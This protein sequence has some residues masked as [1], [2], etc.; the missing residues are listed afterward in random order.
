MGDVL[1]P[2][3]EMIGDAAKADDGI[4][5]GSDGCAGW[6]GGKSMQ[7]AGSNVRG[8]AESAKAGE[9][10]ARQMEGG[11]AYHGVSKKGLGSLAGVRQCPSID[12]D[13]RPVEQVGRR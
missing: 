11:Q 3:Q 7:Q 10:A 9:I 6:D 12:G 13:P 2:C 4:A 5:H 1:D 8:H